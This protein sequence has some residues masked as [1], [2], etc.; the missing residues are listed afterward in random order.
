MLKLRETAITV[1]E[2]TWPKR[3]ILCW[4]S[5]VLGWAVSCQ[6]EMVPSLP[7]VMSVRES[8]KT[9]VDIWDWWRCSKWPHCW[10]LRGVMLATEG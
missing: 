3:H 7:A 5:T 10:G 4:R 1:T 2:E 8:A 9:A 6:T